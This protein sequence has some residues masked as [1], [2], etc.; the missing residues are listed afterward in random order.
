M[1]YLGERKNKM[2]INAT[3]TPSPARAEMTEWAENNIPETSGFYILHFENEVGSGE[4]GRA[5]HYCGSA[6]N[7]RKRFLQHLGGC[8]FGGARLT[9]VA[10]EKGIKFFMAAAYQTETEDDARAYEAYFKKCAKNGRRSC[11]CCGGKKL[12]CPKKG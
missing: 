7:L 2:P 1:V 5:Q 6:K 3:N 10:N 12:P 11:P 9:E 4:M 8:G